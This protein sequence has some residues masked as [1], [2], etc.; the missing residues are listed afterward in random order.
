[1]VVFQGEY[2]T[3]HTVFGVAANNSSVFNTVRD[4]LYDNLNR[5]PG[6]KDG[7]ALY[8]WE[9]QEAYLLLEGTMLEKRYERETD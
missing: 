4:H 2:K 1:M 3:P 6:K 5:V 8:L 9:G 7:E